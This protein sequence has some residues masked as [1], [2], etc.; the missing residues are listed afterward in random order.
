MIIKKIIEFINCKKV[1]LKNKILSTQDYTVKMQYTFLENTFK[2]NKLYKLNE[3]LNHIRNYRT[4]TPEMTILI[5]EMDKEELIHI[6]HI[7]C[8][9]TDNLVQIFMID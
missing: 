7:S 8:E 3:V 2:E 4:I 9:C 1:H 6:I 5:S